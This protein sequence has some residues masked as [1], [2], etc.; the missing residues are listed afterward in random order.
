MLAARAA[1]S[2]TFWT[3]GQQEPDQ[4]R[5]DGDHDQQLDQRERAA[6]VHV[7]SPGKL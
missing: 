6:T 5:Q 2:R 1:A 3:A 7:G 4:D